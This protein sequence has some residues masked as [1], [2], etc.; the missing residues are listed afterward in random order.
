V[1][2]DERGQII[3]IDDGCSDGYKSQFKID[4]GE[5]IMKNLLEA[6]KGTKFQIILEPK[7]EKN[8]GYQMI[9]MR[10]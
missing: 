8:R 1:Q 5:M 7:Y 4:K 3:S 9:E 6:P 10:K 2:G